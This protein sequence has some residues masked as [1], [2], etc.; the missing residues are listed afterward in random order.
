MKLAMFVAASALTLS[1]CSGQSARAVT[2]LDCPMTEG[3]LTRVSAAGDGKSC[4]YRSTDGAEVVLELVSF[5]GDAQVTLAGIEKQLL[6]EAAAE[7]ALANGAEA[8]AVAPPVSS[9][10]AADAARAHAE[11]VADAG[12]A[13]DRSKQLGVGTVDGPDGDVT[14]VDLPGIHVVADDANDTAKIEIGPLKVDASDDDTSVRIFREVRMR[15]E[16]L[17]RERR[18]LR[19]TFIYTGKDLPAGYRYVS[20][21]AGGPKTGP[22]A[23]A[24]IR[25]K[26][27][28]EAGDDINHDVEELVRRNGGV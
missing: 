3:E 27:S 7:A 10:T 6:S 24:K 22:L 21:Q 5:T 25:T 20:Y 16:A 17:S 14:R 1:A 2:K 26:T 12:G 9:S 23:I 15:G 11:A 18:G 8:T 13:E 28:A 19:A 4:L